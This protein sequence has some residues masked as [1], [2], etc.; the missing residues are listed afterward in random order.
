MTNKNYSKDGFVFLKSILFI[1]TNIFE[2]ELLSSWSGG[3]WKLMRYS[4]V[5]FYFETVTGELFCD[6]G[7][8]AISILSICRGGGGGGGGG[9][10]VF[11]YDYQHY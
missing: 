9:G 7:E 3:R 6:K 5:H 8:F 11:N 2:R 1:N 10:G 4:L